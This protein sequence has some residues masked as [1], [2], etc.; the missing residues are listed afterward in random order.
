MSSKLID[1]TGQRFG[2]LEVIERYGYVQRNTKQ[3]TWLCR[4]ECGNATVVMGAK[5]RNGTTNSCGCLKKKNSVTHGGS[6][7][8]TYQSWRAMRERCCNPNNSHYAS[9]G[10]R[11]IT[12]CDSWQ[13][14][15]EAFITD[16]GER[17]PGTSID[18]I[19]I[20]K[21]Y[22]P[23]NC[24]WATAKEQ[25]RN[26]TRSVNLTYMGETLCVKD[27]A[28]RIGI[29]GR[30]LSIRLKKMSL[31]EAITIKRCAKKTGVAV[32]MFKEAGVILELS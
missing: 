19:D 18:R 6:K 15:Y 20:S 21:G 5:L 12:V 4:C 30:A 11:G 13:H 22:E 29:T 28:S 31:E 24:R 9:Y 3:P 1:L 2:N 27:W 23:T 16:M 25:S 17:P 10:G 26:T 32:Q 8:S 14:S 7:S